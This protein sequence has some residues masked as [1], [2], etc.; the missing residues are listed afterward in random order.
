VDELTGAQMIYIQSGIF[1]MGNDEGETD[2][3]P[4]HIVRLDAYFIDETEV[5]NGQYRVCVEVGECA[6][7]DRPGATYHEAYYGDPGFD[8][9]PVI[10]VNWYDARDFCAWRGVRLPSEAEWERAAGF[11]PVQAVKFRYT[12]GDE[13]DGTLLN[14]CD[15]RCSRSDRDISVDDGHA[16]TA[17]VGSYS[18]GRSPSGLFDMLGNIMEWVADWYDSRYYAQSTDVNPQGP[19]QGDFKVIRGGSWLSGQDDVRVTA[20]SSLDPTVSRANLGF[21]CAV[22]AP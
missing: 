3:A 21:R 5:T 8:D 17:P 22:T 20:R 15:A 12:W 19:L 14:F 7:P 9:Y 1:R 4:S 16:D 13:F 2:E 11:D 10:F 18:G 6:P